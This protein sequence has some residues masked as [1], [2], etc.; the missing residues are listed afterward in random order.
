MHVYM[1]LQDLRLHQFQ[2][3][4]SDAALFENRGCMCVTVAGASELVMERGAAEAL[5]LP[6]YEKHV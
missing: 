5:W 1:G 2:D 4:T 3:L 6:V